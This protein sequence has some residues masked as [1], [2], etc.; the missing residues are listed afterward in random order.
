MKSLISPEAFEHELRLIAAESIGWQPL[1][2]G[3]YLHA[4]RPDE[5]DTVISVVGVPDVSLA[6]LNAL[7]LT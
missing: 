4:G 6:A 5:D 7:L 1:G 2:S 3:A